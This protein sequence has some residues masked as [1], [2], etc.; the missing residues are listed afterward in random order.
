MSQG[1]V[2]FGGRVRLASVAFNSASAFFLSILGPFIL[3]LL[4]L[5]FMLGLLLLFK[6]SSA[7]AGSSLLTNDSELVL[8]IG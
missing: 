3:L 2:D 5:A 6:S 1:S 8:E 7:S 4:E